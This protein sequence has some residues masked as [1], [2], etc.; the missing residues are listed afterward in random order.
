[1]IDYAYVLRKKLPGIEWS[2]NGDSYQGLTMLDDTPIPTEEQLIEWAQEIKAEDALTQYQRDR[3]RE[4]IKRGCAPDKLIVALWEHVI[5]GSP[6]MAIDLQATRVSIK[7]S[8]P[9]PS[10]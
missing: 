9:K 8:L 5:E 1:M 10:L 7:E 3:E 6:A 4:Y 2:L